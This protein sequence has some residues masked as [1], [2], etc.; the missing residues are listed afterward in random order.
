MDLDQKIS[1]VHGR[2]NE[3]AK[4]IAAEIMRK[5]ENRLLRRYVSDLC[6]PSE[7]SEQIYLLAAELLTPA[8]DD[9]ELQ[10][11]W[12]QRLEM[13]SAPI[14][15]C[16]KRIDFIIPRGVLNFLCGIY[17]SE[18]CAVAMAAAELIAEERHGDLCCLIAN[19]FIERRKHRLGS[20]LIAVHLVIDEDTMSLYNGSWHEIT[21]E[22]SAYIP[23][24]D[25]R[26]Y[27]R[28]DL[29]LSAMVDIAPRSIYVY[30]GEKNLKMLRRIQLMFSGVM[31]Q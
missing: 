16:L 15:D 31:V 20:K 8:D 5:Y 9:E 13:I 28:S 29:V 21:D 24:E 4:D 19:E 23:P 25:R 18:I 6:L 22:Y 30:G 1:V 17:R 2:E 26:R 11:Y 7:E 3:L 27:S 10:G 12:E 14:E